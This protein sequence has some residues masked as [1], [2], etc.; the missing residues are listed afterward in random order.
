MVVERSC[1]SVYSLKST[2]KQSYPHPFPLPSE[3]ARGSFRLQER[4]Q[5]V[6][7]KRTRRNL[8]ALRAFV[9]K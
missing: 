8:R 2:R 6:C 5:V 3:W 4:S 1:F 7:A 9:V